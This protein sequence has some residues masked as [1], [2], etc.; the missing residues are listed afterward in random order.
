MP[1]LVLLKI[2]ADTESVAHTEF[3]ETG[4][5]H[6]ADPYEEVTEDTL[7]FLLGN[8]QKRRD[9]PVICR[10]W[11]HLLSRPSYVWA[12]LNT[13]FHELWNIQQVRFAAVLSSSFLPVK[14]SPYIALAGQ[15]PAE[16]HCLFSV[17]LQRFLDGEL[18]VTWVRQRA[19]GIRH[20]QLDFDAWSRRY[21]QGSF[22]AVQSSRSVA[23]LLEVL[24]DSLQ[25]LKIQDTSF[26]VNTTML[27]SLAT[28]TNLQHLQLFGVSSHVL[29]SDAL[30]YITCLSQLKNLELADCKDHRQAVQQQQHPSFFP[31]QICNLPNLITLHIQ[32]P[33][34]TYIAP[35]ISALSNLHSL[36]I[37]GS[38]L[39][40]VSSVL[41]QL[42]QL[43]TLCLADN[44][45]LGLDK[46][47]EEWWPSELTK[48][49]SL[50]ELDLSSCGVSGVPVSLGRLAHLS[51]LDLCANWVSPG[52]MVPR[53]IGSC[54]AIRTIHMSD[55]K[56]E[57]VPD[58]LCMLT[59]MEYLGLANNK[60][61]D[62]P[63]SIISLGHLSNLDLAQNHF[64]AF[65]TV[66]AGLTKLARISFK[67][68]TDMQISKPLQLL[69]SLCQLTALIFT[70]DLTR[71]EPRWSADSTSNLISLALDFATAHGRDMKIMRL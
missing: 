15:T 43:H 70:C 64:Q 37:N 48:L 51:R 35:A 8:Y 24:Q 62:L 33:L 52:I 41:V 54:K 71:H 39:E 10:R 56:L 46:A 1:D 16:T 28:A 61:V 6:N 30:S 50:K 55:C 26:V 12:S 65:P 25:Q 17:C 29:I 4:E 60:L 11:N 19:S 21:Y 45:S 34:V 67:G 38:S 2:F 27:H 18:L 66:L 57:N 36:M 14:V 40:E 53:D 13:D 42:P 49:I 63:A 7:T 47:P 3:G 31:T 22:S 68:C 23:M 58:C 59:A 20:M 44:N 32:S 5:D 69:T 9:L